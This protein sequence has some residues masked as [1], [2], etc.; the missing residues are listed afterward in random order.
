M[1]RCQRKGESCRVYGIGRYINAHN[2]A[3]H[4]YKR[5]E[6]YQHP[7]HAYHIEHQMGHGCDG[8]ALGIRAFYQRYEAGDDDLIDYDTKTFKYVATPKGMNLL[9]VAYL[10]SMEKFVKGGKGVK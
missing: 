6:E 3:Y 9:K 2:A 1:E 8:V 5:E 7:N 10:R 4:P